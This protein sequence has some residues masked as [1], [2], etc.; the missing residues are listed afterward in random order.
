MLHRLSICFARKTARAS[1]SARS[2]IAGGSGLSSPER[3]IRKP[4]SRRGESFWWSACGIFTVWLAANWPPPSGKG[5]S[6]TDL[7]SVASCRSA[8]KHCSWDRRA[9]TH[10]GGQP[11]Q[12]RVPRDVQFGQNINEL[13]QVRDYAI[14]EGLFH[15]FRPHL[16]AV[17][18]PRG[19]ER[20]EGPTASRSVRPVVCECNKAG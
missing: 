7:T 2:K 8:R 15:S 14:A 20:S 13:R 5:L 11:F 12:F 3:A 10:L 4:A 9:G 18:Q 19:P 17:R 6:A 16:V 1:P